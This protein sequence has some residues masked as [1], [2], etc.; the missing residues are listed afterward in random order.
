MFM[1]PPNRPIHVPQDSLPNPLFDGCVLVI[2]YRGGREF[3]GTNDYLED[4]SINE[5]HGVLH[6]FD[7]ATLGRGYR[8]SVGQLG[9]GR[10]SVGEVAVRER[11]EENRRFLDSHTGN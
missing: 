2:D 5:C 4:V 3:D 9:E 1:N 11:V 8:S 6:G 10:P 7:D